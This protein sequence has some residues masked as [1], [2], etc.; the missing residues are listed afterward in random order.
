MALLK[1]RLHSQ[2]RSPRDGDWWYLVFDTETK[3]FCVEHEWRHE[4]AP[5]EEA[6]AGGTV[7]LEISAY[8][9]TREEGPGQRELI[10]LIKGIFD[11][12]RP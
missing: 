1:R 5:G 8:L 7:P 11:D 10:R 3:R 9:V 12:R 4:A 6:P 2:G